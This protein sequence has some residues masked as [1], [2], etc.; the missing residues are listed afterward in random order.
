MEET[1]T[2]VD[3]IKKCQEGSLEAFDELVLKYQKKVFNVA[4]RLLDN[5]DEANDIAQEVFVRVF[6][7]IKGFRFKAQIFTW[8]YRITVNLSKNRLRVL[9]GERKRNTSLDDPISTEEG[10]MK[11]QVADDSPLPQDQ[12]INKEKGELIAK[13]LASLED[14]FRTVV[15]LR[16]IEGLGYKEI[17][18]ILKI[19]I[20]TVKSRLHRARMLLR[21]KLKGVLR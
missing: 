11:R 5:Y 14:E 15:V 2:D 1:S 18:C 13:A 6:R 17:A 16:D 7:A 20:G 21:E 4:Y 12:L 8:L 10:E 9:A 19:N 3:L